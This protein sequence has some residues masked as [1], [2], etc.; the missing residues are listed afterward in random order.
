MD[1]HADTFVLGVN[2]LVIQYHGRPVNILSYDP[3]LGYHAYQ[4]VSSVIGYDHPITG[5][6]YHLVIHQAISIPHLEHHLLFPMQSCVNE[7]IINEIPKFLASNAT[8]E[9]HFIIVTDPD[10]PVQRVILP[11]AICG[12]TKYLPTWPITKLEC[13]SGLYPSL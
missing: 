10:D 12:V 9:T 8:N 11:L 2:A 1:S 13:E 5:Q 7:V 4:K 6:T 3:A